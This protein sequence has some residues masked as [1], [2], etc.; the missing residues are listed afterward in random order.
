MKTFFLKIPESGYNK[1]VEYYRSHQINFIQNEHQS[2]E[3]TQFQFSTR[4]TDSQM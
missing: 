3:N 1:I 2:L 4:P